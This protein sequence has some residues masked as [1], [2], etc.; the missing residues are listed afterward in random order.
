MAIGR[1]NSSKIAEMFD[2]ASLIGLINLHFLCNG[3][4]LDAKFHPFTEPQPSGNQLSLSV[5]LIKH[6]NGSRLVQ[7]NK[8]QKPAHV[9]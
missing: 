5:T 3:H 7:V 4:V 6:D 1:Q 9:D 8:L 2:V